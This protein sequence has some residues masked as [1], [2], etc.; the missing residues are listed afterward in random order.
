[1]AHCAPAGQSFV[2]LTTTT[3]HATCYG[4]FVLCSFGVSSRHTRADSQVYVIRP[5]ACSRSSAREEL[6]RPESRYQMRLRKLS[7]VHTSASALSPHRGSARRPRALRMPPP[8]RDGPLR[9]PA[10]RTPPRPHGCVHAVDQHVLRGARGRVRGNCRPPRS[11]LPRG[12][13]RAALRS[14]NGPQGP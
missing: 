4:C 8:W 10:S 13:L 9:R 1:M 7:P 2:D 6:A 14:A 12:P 5:W 11:C 3:H